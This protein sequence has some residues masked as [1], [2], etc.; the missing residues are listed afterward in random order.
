MSKLL[1][2]GILIALAAGS[3]PDRLCLCRKALE[4]DLP[5]G[6]NETVEYSEKTVKRITGRVTYWYNSEPAKDMVVEIYEITQADTKRKPHEIIMRRERRAACITSNDGSFC[7]PHL[8][9]GRY[10]LR[11]GAR[12][13]NAGMNEVFMKVKLDRRWWSRWFRSGKDIELGLTAGT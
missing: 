5:H 2:S 6:A 11:A 1:L 13:S 10:L 8:P 12:S 7:F 3:L 9:S 4:H